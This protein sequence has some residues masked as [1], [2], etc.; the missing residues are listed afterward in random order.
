MNCLINA[1]AH[2]LQIELLSK[3]HFSYHLKKLDI[4]TISS[5]NCV[6]IVILSPKKLPIATGDSGR[7]MNIA[8]ADHY[9]HRFCTLLK[10]D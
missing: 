7:I 5:F 9:H 6:S 1:C 3:L 8:N 10:S 2:L 4:A